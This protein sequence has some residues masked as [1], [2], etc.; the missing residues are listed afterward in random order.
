VISIFIHIPTVFWL[1]LYH[2]GSTTF[3]TAKII[4]PIIFKA[5]L[6]L[7]KL[8]LPKFF[9]SLFGT[10]SAITPSTPQNIC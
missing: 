6:S 10:S 4:L 8:T 1:N 9:K 5:Y 2:I 3:Y 7:F